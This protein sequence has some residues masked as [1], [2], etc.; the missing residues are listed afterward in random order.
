MNTH[1]SVGIPHYNNARYMPDTLRH[2]IDDSR[3]NEIVI[4]DDVSKDL[5]ALEKYLI[6]IN[7]SKIKLYKNP[8]NLGCYLNKLEV[9]SKCTNDYVLILDSD[10]SVNDDTINILYNLKEWNE[11]IIYAPAWAKT[12]PGIPSPNLDYRSMANLLVDK[13]Y[14]LENFDVQRFKCLMN[15]CNY[16]LPKINYLNCMNKYKN[17]YIRDEIDS[18]DSMI[19]LSDW[20]ENNNNKLFIV[21]DFIYN[22]RLHSNSNYVKAIKKYENIIFQR[23]KYKL[24]R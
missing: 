6:S 18:L 14:C 3:I 9:I 16:F 7:S 1:I 11:N 24:I 20:F 2:I 17:L 13:K 5:D 4:C 12:F 15:T 21:K 23:I 8:K 19:L 22:H 10:N